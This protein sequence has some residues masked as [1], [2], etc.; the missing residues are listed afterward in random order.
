MLRCPLVEAAQVMFGLNGGM[1]IPSRNCGVAKV[2][3]ARGL[4]VQQYWKAASKQPVHS[5][6]LHVCRVY[7]LAL[8]ERHCFRRGHGYRRVLKL[9]IAYMVGGAGS[10]SP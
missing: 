10:T 3:I 8:I 5:R 7:H 6:S 2:A 4:A 1:Q 9:K